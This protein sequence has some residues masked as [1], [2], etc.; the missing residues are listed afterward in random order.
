MIQFSPSNILTGNGIAITLT[1]MLIVFSGLLLISLF[2]SSLPR[3]LSWLDQ[4]KQKTPAATDSSISAQATELTEPEIHAA[5]SL[6]LHLELERCGGDLQRITIHERPAMASFW[7]PR[8]Q[9]RS[10]SDRS[11]YA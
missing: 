7:N 1:G 5:I 2:I 6:V 4:L 8:G 11:P 3:L 10:L 9:M